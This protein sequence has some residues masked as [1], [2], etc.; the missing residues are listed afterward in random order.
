MVSKD[1]SSCLRRVS[2]GH[3]ARCGRNIRHTDVLLTFPILA[4]SAYGH[5]CFLDYTEHSSTTA[6]VDFTFPITE[7][8]LV[9]ILLS[10]APGVVPSNH[11]KE[12]R[13]PNRY[14]CWSPGSFRQIPTAMVHVSN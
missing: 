3:S 1:V 2:I 9:L 6:R 12:Q 14:P 4:I 13:V 8:S 11:P 5:I 7:L 10:L